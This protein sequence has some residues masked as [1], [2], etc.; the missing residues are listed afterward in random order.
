MTSPPPRHGVRARYLRGCRCDACTTT[1]KRY[2]AHYHLRRQQGHQNRVPAEPAADHIDR[3]LTAGWTI[4]AIA[5]T[6]SVPCSTIRTLTQRTFRHTHHSVAA[7][8]LTVHGPP[9]TAPHRHI[10]ATGA[11]R[12]LQALA[13]MGHPLVRV[14]AATG[15]HAEVLRRIARGD[16][17]TI[18]YGTHQAIAD[19]Y[20][21]WCHIP[22]P[23]ARAR[24]AAAR[25]GWHGPL[26]WSDIDNPAAEPEVDSE[27]AATRPA[28]RAAAV[29]DD[30]QHLA[31][32]GLSTHEIASRVG[33]TEK[34]V[35]EQ[36]A[37]RKRAQV[38]MAA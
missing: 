29:A 22:G 6:A 24:R 33:R 38:V 10:D 27:P 20:R 28:E 4:P 5:R 34:Y 32:C 1:H 16:V 35:R 13:A 30:I 17:T 19:L 2:M 23:S 26:A 18:R 25:R 36:I 37:G 12:R 15:H 9:P 11:A 7:K 14:A 21:V 3:L 8:V 31:G